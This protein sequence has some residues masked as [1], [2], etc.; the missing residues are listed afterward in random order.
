[1]DQKKTSTNWKTKNRSATVRMMCRDNDLLCQEILPRM[2][3]VKTA[4]NARGVFFGK[5]Q[6]D[7]DGIIRCAI[8]I[9]NFLM[10]DNAVQYSYQELYV[11]EFSIPTRNR[12][13]LVVTSQRTSVTTCPTCKS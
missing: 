9:S 11:S 6:T 10:W 8:A 7:E 2:E 5:V 4:L 3:S 12:S 1:M 13:F